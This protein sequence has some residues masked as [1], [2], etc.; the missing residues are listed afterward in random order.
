MSESGRKMSTSMLACRLGELESIW[1]TACTSQSSNSRFSACDS[2][3]TPD[4][5]AAKKQVVAPSPREVGAHK[6]YAEACPKKRRDT[7]AAHDVA[8]KKDALLS[9]RTQSPGRKPASD[10]RAGAPGRKRSPCLSGGTAKDHPT[11]ATTTSG[12]KKKSSLTPRPIAKPSPPVSPSKG[13]R[14]ALMH[15]GASPA[16][17]NS[18]TTAPKETAK[19]PSPA[20]VPSPASV[21]EAAPSTVR[22]NKKEQ[23]V[24]SSPSKTAVHTS[25]QSSLPVPAATSGRG[26]A[27]QQTC[28]AKPSL[29]V[30]STTTQ[31]R[32]TESPVTLPLIAP[33]LPPPLSP[34]P[35]G[36][37]FCAQCGK[38][39]RV[40]AKFCSN[41]GVAL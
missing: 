36:T 22:E 1:A 13:S 8:V 41:C 14:S 2:G 5:A 27:A 16:N 12:E 29:T 30:L 39:A 21:K 28:N 26:S 10:E 40:A 37:R 34:N 18:P 4:A 25:R 3:A 7:T 17:A 15:R 23:K 38:A 32:K 24:L 20:A 11:S 35:G 19:R 31:E 33:P 9:N 6:K